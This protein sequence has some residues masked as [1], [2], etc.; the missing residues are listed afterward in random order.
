MLHQSIGNQLDEDGELQLLL[1]QF[2]DWESFGGMSGLN[3]KYVRSRIDMGGRGVV[4]WPDE[5]FERQESNSLRTR[6]FNLWVKRR[7][8]GCDNEAKDE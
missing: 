5:M 3:V 6:L 7:G 2:P 1:Q 8:V 4:G